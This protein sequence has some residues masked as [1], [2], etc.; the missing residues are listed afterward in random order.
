MEDLRQKQCDA[1]TAEQL[2]QGKKPLSIPITRTSPLSS[3]VHG[4]KQL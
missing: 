4:E 3:R 2:M 1:F